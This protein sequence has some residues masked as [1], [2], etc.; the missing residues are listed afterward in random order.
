[1]I[2]KLETWDGWRY[3]RTP[4]LPWVHIFFELSIQQF[5]QVYDLLE[6]PFKPT[7][8]L[9]QIAKDFALTFMIFQDNEDYRT[10]V[11]HVTSVEAPSVDLFEG[12]PSDALYSAKLEGLFTNT[13]ARLEQLRYGN[14]VYQW[15]R[16]NNTFYSD[17]DKRALSAWYRLLARWVIQK[18]FDSSQLPQCESD[19][20]NWEQ[21]LTLLQPYYHPSEEVL[22]PLPL[23]DEILEK[24]QCE[25]LYHEARRIRLVNITEAFL[26]TPR[27][28]WEDFALRAGNADA[29]IPNEGR[30]RINLKTW[31]AVVNLLS[32]DEMLILE[33]WG[34]EHRPQPSYL[35]SHID[36]LVIPFPVPK[37]FGESV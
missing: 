29:R 4:I 3:K 13:F 37:P 22:K 28:V 32:S 17:P 14:A 33:Q 5:D 21:I 10:A 1:M 36:E 20:R 7:E 35:P 8:A 9:R 31:Q 23:S 24:L 18:W 11:A 26:T 2:Y 15:G 30:L 6:F 27:S 25:I 19:G 16:H 34:S 12:I